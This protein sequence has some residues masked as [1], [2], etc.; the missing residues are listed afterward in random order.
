MNVRVNLLN[1][2]EVRHHVAVSRQFTIIASAAGGGALLLLLGLILAVNFLGARREVAQLER[3]WS[4]IEEAHGQALALKEQVE[5]NQRILGELNGWRASRLEWA[6]LMYDMERLVPSSV[7]L[8]RFDVRNIYDMVLA[9]GEKDPRAGTPVRMYKIDMG[10]KAKGEF[11]EDTV[12]QFVRRISE[13]P[14]YADILSSIKLQSLQ[15]DRS[16]TGA[17]AGRL[18]GIEGFTQPREMKP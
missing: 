18:F 6:K 8:T 16:H 12:L 9:E 10:G 11:A 1:E 13:S 17:E 2:D 5:R 4:D 7:Q 3:R 15:K 14:A